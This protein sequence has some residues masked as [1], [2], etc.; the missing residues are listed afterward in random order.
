MKNRPLLF[1]LL[2]CIFFS[3]ISCQ[4]QEAP[5]SPQVSTPLKSGFP[6]TLTICLGYEP[7]SLYLYSAKTQ[8][9]WGVLEAL[10]DGPIDMRNY[11][12]EP[13]ILDALPSFSNGKAVLTSI[14]V[15]KGDH[16]ADIHG[17]PILLVEGAE[18]FPHGCHQTDC[19]I[20]W[21]GVSNLEMDQIKAT[22]QILPGIQW[23]DGQPITARDS[24]FSFQIASDPATPIDKIAVQQTS[25]YQA[26]N[27]L[28]IEWT[29]R[30][31]LLTQSFEGYF[32]L[33]LPLHA[34]GKLSASELLS[35]DLST[36]KPISWGAYI[37]EE[38]QAG[39]FIRLARNPNYFRAREGLPVFDNLV[40]K[41][42]NMQGDT[43]LMAIRRSECDFS[44]Q[45]A[46]MLDQTERLEYYLKYYSIP[47][48]KVFFGSGPLIEYLIFNTNTQTNTKNQKPSLM[49][50]VHMRQAVAYCA[51]RKNLL[52]DFFNQLINVP[53]SFLPENDPHYL[54]NLNP[55]EDDKDLLKGQ[56]ILEEMGWKD[57]D[58]NPDTPRTSANINGLAD[59]TPLTIQF[60]TDQ[61]TWRRNVANVIS[62]SLKKCGFGVELSIQK[63]NEFLA[64]ESPFWNGKFDL[65]EF[66]WASGKTPPCFLFSSDAQTLLD[67]PLNSMDLNVGKFYNPEFD[68]LCSASLQ[69]LVDNKTQQD[70][71]SRLQ[72]LFNN[73]LPALPIFS[74]FWA[75]VARADFCAFSADISAR[76]DLRD[77]EIMDYGTQCA[78]QPTR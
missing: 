46:L 10:Y 6:R 61:S 36:K 15:T 77:I 22:F 42:I 66:A 2:I 76:S 62:R 65:A 31:G 28:T 78:P 52:K 59:G 18:V 55:Y 12:P 40:F 74:Y 73:D 11:Q 49:A 1:F 3:P 19:S 70:L 27:D 8:S 51:D 14:K 71:Q 39:K 56:V 20:H 33:P 43:N 9:A 45:T 21:D 44:N 30:P 54:K 50:D 67:K 32:W 7:E 24:I 64:K 72:T 23:S 5:T 29:G 26:V 57:K 53:L 68:Q 58:K 25:S 60:I 38:W 35:S 37:L 47:E 34:W 4:A 69:P 13:V 17:N 63:T 41:F 16:V 48:I 75:D